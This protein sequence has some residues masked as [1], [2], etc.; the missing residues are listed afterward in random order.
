MW[1]TT[2]TSVIGLLSPKTV[3]VETV[4][5]L[6]GTPDPPVPTGGTRELGAVENVV[7]LPPAPV[8]SEMPG[9]PAA[10]PAPPTSAVP[11][12]AAV[13]AR[14]AAAPDPGRRHVA[15]KR[16]RAARPEGVQ[17]EDA[18]AFGQ[19]AGAA[20]AAEPAEP[21]QGRVGADAGVAAGAGAGAVAAR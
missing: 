18:A 12:V 8:P 10:P 21:G 11:A 13:A 20:G 14:A 15:G 4:V 17:V 9:M 6:A 2:L 19:P 1:T 16:D 3:M 5:S 7:A